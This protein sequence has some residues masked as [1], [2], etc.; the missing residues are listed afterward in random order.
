MQ[1]GTWGGETAHLILAPYRLQS[2]MREM[3]TVAGVPGRAEEQPAICLPRATPLVTEVAV[4]DRSEITSRIR[5]S[6]I[7][8]R[9]I[10]DSGPLLT[11]VRIHRRRMIGACEKT[12]L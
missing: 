7:H 4:L 12:T 5:S 6:E 2:T 11:R 8:G 3:A 9:L 10:F 1:D